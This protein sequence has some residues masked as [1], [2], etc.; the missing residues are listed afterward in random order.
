MNLFRSLSGKIILLIFTIFVVSFVP[1]LQDIAAGEDRCLCGYDG[2]GYYMY[3]P[4]FFNE[5]NLDIKQEWA[6]QLQNEYCDGIYVY[7]IVRTESGKELNAYHLGQAFVELPAYLT[8]D[9]FARIFGFKTDGFSKPYYI[10]F[11]LNV[12]LFVFLGLLYLRKLL[13]LYFDEKITSVTILALYFASNIYIT[14][15]LQNDLQHLYLFALN[16]VFL[17]HTILFVRNKST[18]HLI[19]SA[20]ILG[21][22][23]A[24]RPTQVLLGVFPLI[25]LLNT[26][27][28]RWAFF[29]RIW[30]Y[31]VFGILWNIPQIAYW[32]MI[33]GEPF[34]PNLHSENI[35]LTD[36]NLFDFLF[37]YKKGWLLYSP[38]F[39]LSIHGLYVIFK[40]NRS[41]F[42]SFTLF[43]AIY[44]WVMS[45][46]ECWW[47]SQSYGSRVMV[48]VYPVL[49]VLMAF[50]ISSWKH[51]GVKFL[52]YTFIIG[53]SLLSMLQTHQG[54]RGYLSFENMTKQ[55]YWYI[56]GRIDIPDYDPKHLELNRGSI[57]PDWISR[58]KKL[59]SSDYTYKEKLIYE[60]TEPI[61]V[62]AISHILLEFIVL[63][64]LPSDEGM[65]EFVL[66]SKTSDSTKSVVLMSETL[67]EYKWNWY[68]W[69]PVE[70]SLGQAQN[71][72]VEQSLYI[73][74]QRMR[75]KKDRMNFYFINNEG[76][77]LY[78]ES[79]KI[80]AHTI[81]RE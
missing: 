7:Q 55:H 38:I 45:S 73:N 49:A 65:L 39:L 59:P 12:L 76:V 5:G 21:L 62:E 53:C 50:S 16:A 17:Y 15:Y 9:V 19:I 11:I 6:Q 33:G 23:V 68:N 70:I 60:T 51:R 2:Y 41:L 61:K 74:L 80:I 63:D 13:L 34:I 36:P 8:G 32:W 14:F 26:Y 10:A 46:W 78:V 22:T 77:N 31:P 37:S 30:I 67:T 3:L 29:K 48:D 28:I 52:G 20:L 43:L 57:D 4:H 18:K 44:I 1:K 75:H 24:I 35:I 42:W 47:Y 56:F 58:A 71:K 69:S 79:L 66:T 81:E 72:F 64:N 54:L 40:T 27:G 25:L